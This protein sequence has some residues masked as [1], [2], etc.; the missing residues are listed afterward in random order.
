MDN[1]GR[2]KLLSVLCHG[3]IFLSS[4]FVSIRIPIAV[5]FITDDP[6]LKETVK[7]ALDFHINLYLYA[8]IF[9]LLIL[10][11]T[12]IL[13]LIMLG[14]VTFL[15]PI[16]ALVRVLTEPSQPYRYPFIF[17]LV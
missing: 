15:M 3:S 17:R 13:L 10:V 12:G 2:R 14:V 4:L 7:E 6:I 8:A 1:L 16:V 5:L 9:A 11:A